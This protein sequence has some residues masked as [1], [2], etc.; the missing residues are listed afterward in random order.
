[1]KFFIA[2][3]NFCQCI[4]NFCFANVKAHAKIL[5]SI[6]ETRSDIDYL[7]RGVTAVRIVCKVS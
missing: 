3:L 1:M 5:F 6:E 7:L 2:K 4:V